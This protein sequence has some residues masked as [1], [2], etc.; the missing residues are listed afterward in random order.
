MKLSGEYVFAAEVQEVWDALF[1]PAVLAA[2][3]PGCEKLELVD[4]SYLGE[5][6]VKV[7]PIQGKFTG[8]VDLLDQVA[9]VSYRMVIDGKGPQ[10][11]VKATARIALEP[12]GS[13]TKITYDSD[14]Q[15]G[16]KIATVGERLIE[17]SAKAIVK[18]SLEG[19]GENVVIRAE[20]HRKAKA[21]AAAM[22]PAAPPE[23]DAT[24]PTA[25]A[26]AEPTAAGT[27]ATPSEA[28]AV[29]SAASAPTEAATAASS[30]AAPAEAAASSASAPAEGATAASSV[31]AS[32]AS[33][34]APAPVAPTSAAPALAIEYKRA[35]ASKLAGAVAKEV[36]KAYA[37]IIVVVLLGVAGLIYLIVR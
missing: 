10:G 36:G 26:A 19:L 32:S 33:P 4:G 3:L 16:G 15:V 12:Q 30:V 8:K 9:P 17:T 23:P 11:F 24:S 18:Q 29:A 7:G 2:V 28:S 6:K 5:L 27:V 1:D 37:P 13:S 31:T 21:A 25:T 20:A 14:A 22:V 35:D 34:G